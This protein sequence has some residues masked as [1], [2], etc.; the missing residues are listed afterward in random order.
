MNTRQFVAL[1]APIVL[2]ALGAILAHPLAGV[3]MVV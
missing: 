2:S 3:L 1:F